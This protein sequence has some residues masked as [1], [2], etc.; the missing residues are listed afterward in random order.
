M[1]KGFYRDKDGTTYEFENGKIIN[2]EY[3]IE[4]S[5]LTEDEL[6]KKKELELI[7][8]LYENSGVLFTKTNKT[9]D[10]SSNKPLYKISQVTQNAKKLEYLYSAFKNGKEVTESV[11]L[12]DPDAPKS[13]KIKDIYLDID[14]LE[15]LFNFREAEIEEFGKECEI[16]QI[17]DDNKPESELEE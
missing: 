1:N 9:H 14:N 11:L 13:K 8:G 17:T 4:N 5:E 12:Y 7:A 3:S 6:L 16:E 2:V 10:D 15:E